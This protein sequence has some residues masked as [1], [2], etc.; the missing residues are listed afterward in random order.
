M[1]RRPSTP[2][3]RRRKL[4]RSRSNHQQQAAPEGVREG[5]FSVVEKWK[6]LR[7]SPFKVAVSL[8]ASATITIPG[9]RQGAGDAFTNIDAGFNAE[10]GQMQ[11][12]SE[13]VRIDLS[14]IAFPGDVGLPLVVGGN[15]CLVRIDD[16]GLLLEQV[17]HSRNPA[18]STT[19]PRRP[20][21]FRRSCVNSW[22]GRRVV[23]DRQALLRL[24][25]CR[26]LLARQP[27]RWQGPSRHQLPSA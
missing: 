18:T 7:Y 4:R 9:G 26:A 14:Q 3:A 11:V 27:L 19:A 21:S 12:T 1:C 17:S 13:R 8:Q 10:T 25:P 16:W 23:N 6:R 24:Q 20:S 2:S 5:A 15:N 22:W